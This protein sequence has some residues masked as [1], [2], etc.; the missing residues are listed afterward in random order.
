MIF[1]IDENRSNKL[2]HPIFMIFWLLKD[3]AIFYYTKTQS[4]GK[5]RVELIQEL[6]L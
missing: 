5:M 6:V 2:C 4:K 1:T 3:G